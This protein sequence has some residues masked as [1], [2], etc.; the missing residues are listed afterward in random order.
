METTVSGGEVKS[1]VCRSFVGE[2]YGVEGPFPF[3]SAHAFTNPIPD[4][5]PDRSS[6]WNPFCPLVGVVL[7]SAVSCALGVP[8]ATDD[9]DA[10]DDDDDDDDGASHVSERTVLE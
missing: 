4:P 1:K 2:E 8:V 9:D 5:D 10:D 6:G 3:P 7:L